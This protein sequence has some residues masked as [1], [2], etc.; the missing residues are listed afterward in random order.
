MV[1]LQGT[2]QTMMVN[3]RGQVELLNGRFDDCTME[4]CVDSLAAATR[5][6]QRGWLATVNVAILMM[7]RKDPFLQDFVDRARWVLCDGQPLIWLSRFLG[8]PLRGRL[9]GVDL[10]DPL[11]ARA[12]KE[13]YVVYFLGASQ[14]IIEQAAA[15][16]CGRHPG[17][18]CHFA[19]GYFS[20]EEASARADEVARAGTDWLVVG[21]GVPRQERF[22]SEQWD[23]LDVSVAIGVGG[24]FDVIAGLRRRAPEMV[25]KAGMEWG[26]RL[27]QE[28]KRLWRR[29]LQ[30]NS[31]FTL[32]AA[33]EI[34]HKRFGK[35]SQPALRGPVA[36]IHSDKESTD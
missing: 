13:G 15:K 25:Q 33:R 20:A 7:M 1:N 4:G 22:I 18:K 24:S 3:N 31:Q 30:T 23:R 6:G 27:A 32:L 19:N 16:I 28:P 8:T 9:T 14:E 35:S 17:L 5:S 36:P 26:Y 34:F 10:I 12:A 29:Y 2:P 21:M 11:C